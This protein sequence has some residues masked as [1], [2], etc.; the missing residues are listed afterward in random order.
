VLAITAVLVVTAPNVSEAP[1]P[2]ADVTSDVSSA[3]P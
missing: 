2:T 1:E 3:T